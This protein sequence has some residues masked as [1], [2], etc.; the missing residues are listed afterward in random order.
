M[1]VEKRRE[2]RTH[3]IEELNKELEDH[4]KTMSKKDKD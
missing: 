4:N 1:T 2:A 3:K